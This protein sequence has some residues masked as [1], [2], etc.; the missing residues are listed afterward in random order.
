MTKQEQ[1]KKKV[2]QLMEF[3]QLPLVSLLYMA[4]CNDLHHQCAEQKE[5]IVSVIG[6]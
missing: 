3:L 1:H 5:Q 4:V 2:E 6:R